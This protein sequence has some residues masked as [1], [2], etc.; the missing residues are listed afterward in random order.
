MGISTVFHGM[1]IY[2]NY[3]PLKVLMV[4]VKPIF[5]SCSRFEAVI[6]WFYSIKPTTNNGHPMQ[7]PACPFPISPPKN[8][9]NL[10]FGHPWQ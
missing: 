4:A 1:Q 10:P 7:K 8:Q 5:I 9:G 6:E 2:G 3:R